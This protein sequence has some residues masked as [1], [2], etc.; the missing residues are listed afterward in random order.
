MKYPSSPSCVVA[1]L[2]A[3]VGVA[4]P[5]AHA[6]ST[7]SALSHPRCG[8]STPPT[9]MLRRRSIWRPARST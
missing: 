6:T 3:F 9:A 7:A 4:S 2:L 1:V 5:A 8:R